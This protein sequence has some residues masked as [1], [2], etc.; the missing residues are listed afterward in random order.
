MSVI[1]QAKGGRTVMLFAP[2][3]FQGRRIT[4]VDFAPPRLEHTL[5]W[6]A[7]QIETSLSL[8]SE[9]SGLE[10]EVLKQIR[11]PD[12][13]VMVEAFVSMLPPEIRDN[14]SRAEVPRTEQAP[15]PQTDTE[16]QPQQDEVLPPTPETFPIPDVPLPGSVPP[17]EA[18]ELD[19]MGFGVNL[20]G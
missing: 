17:E 7:G 9:L 11:Y 8:M 10:E 1:Y 13:N 2:F 3:T 20:D 6:Q 15:E 4:R 16:L 18:P 12:V 5:R 14:M 19:P